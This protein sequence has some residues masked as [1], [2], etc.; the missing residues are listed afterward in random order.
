MPTGVYENRPD[1][2]D[3]R[4]VR[5]DERVL[6]PA[7]QLFCLQLMGEK[8]SQQIRIAFFSGSHLENDIR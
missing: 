8:P 4:A 7:G 1:V 3:V 6:R 2:R 5:R